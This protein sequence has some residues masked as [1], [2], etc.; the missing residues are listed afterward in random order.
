MT[1]GKIVKNGYV[2]T[3]MEAGGDLVGGYYLIIASTW[4]D[5]PRC[6]IR[7]RSWL[8]LRSSNEDCASCDHSEDW[9]GAESRGR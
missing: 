1:Q 3:T 2:A 8:Q 9:E 6:I 5:A 7:D 4:F